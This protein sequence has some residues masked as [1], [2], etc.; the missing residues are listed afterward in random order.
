[1]PEYI[2][3][4]TQQFHVKLFVILDGSTAPPPRPSAQVAIIPI[5]VLHYLVELYDYRHSIRL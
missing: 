2:I 5:S 3:S 4:S 1:M